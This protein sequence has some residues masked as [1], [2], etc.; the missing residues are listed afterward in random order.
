MLASLYVFLDQSKLMWED[1]SKSKSEAL[2]F[3]LFYEY[4]VFSEIW[5]SG[6]Q[7]LSLLH[8]SWKPQK[9]VKDSEPFS[10]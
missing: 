2:P 1:I 9:E 8:W 4:T 3:K 7:N 5:Y 10:M 6:E